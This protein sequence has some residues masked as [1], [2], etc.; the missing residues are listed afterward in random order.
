MSSTFWLKCPSCGRNTK[1]KV[2]EDTALIHFPLYCHWCKKEFLVN[3]FDMK[4]YVE[5]QN[6][7]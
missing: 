4:L 3:L 7:E 2:R 1:T 5:K 6:A